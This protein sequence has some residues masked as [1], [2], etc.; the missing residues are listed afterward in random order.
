MTNPSSTVESIA[1]GLGIGD[2]HAAKATRAGVSREVHNFI[3]DVEDLVKDT[4]SLTGD[5]LAKAKATLSERI[6]AAR[7]S[8]D[9]MSSAVAK[10]ARNTASETNAYVHDQPWKAVGIGAAIGLLLGVVISR[11]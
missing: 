8:I 4:T 11:R 6:S 9:A 5:E 3:A 2:S 1:N 7:Q 10:R